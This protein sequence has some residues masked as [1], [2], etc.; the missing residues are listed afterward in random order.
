MIFKIEDEIW[1][2]TGKLLETATTNMQAGTTCKQTFYSV[3][4]DLYSTVDTIVVC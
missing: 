4:L 1:D 3:R 2:R